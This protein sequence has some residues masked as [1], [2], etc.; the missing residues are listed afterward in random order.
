MNAAVLRAFADGYLTTGSERFRGTAGA[1]V[2]FLRRELWLDPGFAGSLDREGRRDETQCADTTAAAADALV[3]YA[4][5]TD[6]PTARELGEATLDHLR[7]VF[8]SGGTV[9]HVHERSSESNTG[10]PSAP[11][12]AEP[13]VSSGAEPSVSNG[14]EPPVDLLADVAWTV[15]AFTT[16]QQVL[17]S[18]T[19]TAR[20]VADRALDRLTGPITE[21]AASPDGSKNAPT[22]EQGDA[23]TDE[24]NP[25]HVAF[26]D[27]PTAGPGLLDRPLWPADEGARLADALVDLSILTGEDRYRERARAAM[28]ALADATERMGVQVAVYG[29]AVERLRREPLVIAVATPPGSDL[30]RAALRVADHGKVVVPEA[31]GPPADTARVRGSDAPPAETPAELARAVERRV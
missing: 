2:R 7:S 1:I 12:G 28:A 14:A 10:E 17:G 6:D 13:S 15:R 3:A 26:R 29:R 27:G 4:G 21:D 31:D 22:G 24:S 19:D 8:V 18:G 23:K 20:R 25:R 9:T 16:A 30:H 5:Y 11:S